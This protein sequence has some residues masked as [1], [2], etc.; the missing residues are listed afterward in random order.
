MQ[1][2]NHSSSIQSSEEMFIDVWNVEEAVEVLIEF[3][4]YADAYLTILSIKVA[5]KML[6]ILL[7]YL[8]YFKP[9]LSK[10]I[11]FEN[12]YILNLIISLTFPGNLVCSLK[13]LPKHLVGWQLGLAWCAGAVFM[14]LNNGSG[15]VDIT[16]P[17]ELMV[18]F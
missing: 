17:V 6:Y 14:I 8:K 11:Y 12:I 1:L 7:D 18:I 2:S 4:W 5:E 13:S 10:F 3:S 16:H 9:K 15:R